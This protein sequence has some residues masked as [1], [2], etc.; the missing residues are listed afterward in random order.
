MSKRLLLFLTSFFF[1]SAYCCIN[2]TTVT[3]DGKKVESEGMYHVPLGHRFE[4]DKV[5]YE[6]K[7]H[8]LDSLWRRNKSLDDYSDYGVHLVYLGRYKEAKDVFSNIELRQ[9]GRYTTAANIGTIY[10][11]LGQNDSALH[12]IKRAVQIDPASHYHSEWIHVKILEAK[13]GGKEKITSTF[14]IGTEFGTDTI[15]ILPMSREELGKLRE[16]LYFQLNERVS[17]IKPKDEIVALLLFELGNIAALEDDLTTA[18]RIYERAIEYGY[19]SEVLDKRH[20]KFRSMLKG[21]TDE[22]DEKH[23]VRVKAKVVEEGNRMQYYVV[24]GLLLLVAGL[25]IW[26]RKQSA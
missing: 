26:I 17:F 10:E 11:L 7:L 18:I 21:I 24:G 3:L 13:I 22:F 14:L 6:Q 15:P 2:E 9:P 5:Y 16:A 1:I 19:E 8:E 20:A 23:E 25:F 4:E 12:W